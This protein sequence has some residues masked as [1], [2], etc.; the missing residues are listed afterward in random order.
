MYLTSD[1]DKF[2]GLT[3]SLLII[4]LTDFST[5]DN[6]KKNSKLLS[7]T[8]PSTQRETVM[9]V[10]SYFQPREEKQ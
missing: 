2:T 8:L 3:T 9:T 7:L 1:K 4:E 6:S 5:E 10:S